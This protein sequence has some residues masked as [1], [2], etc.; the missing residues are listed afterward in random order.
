MSFLNFLSRRKAPR[1][2]EKHPPTPESGPT[3][4]IE[5]GPRTSSSPI[6][7]LNSN[8][9]LHDPN[10]ISWSSESDPHNPRNW[11][12]SKKFLNVGLL[13]FMSFLA[14][15]ASSMMAPGVMQI[16]EEFHSTNDLLASFVVSVYVL[17]FAIGPLI[18]A[19]LS[20]MYGRL[21]MYYICEV[22]FTVFNMAC[23]ESKNLGSLIAFRFLAGLF[24]G[25]PLANG[26]GSIS[27]MIAQETRGA[28]MAAFAMGLLMGPMLGPVM[29]GYLA[30]AEGWRWVFHV[31]SIAVS[32]FPKTRLKDGSRLM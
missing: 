29:G 1:E 9:D 8:D 26:G 22:L 25:V 24:G 23:A 16:M 14:P 6:L 17:G 5:A 2:V 30:Q 21:P 11:S 10:I 12:K 18:F 20:E 13:S 31:I 27:D 4:D 19:P 28:S 15:L 3:P 7:N 32:Q